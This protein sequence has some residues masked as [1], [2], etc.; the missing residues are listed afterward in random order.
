M[1]AWYYFSGWTSQQIPGQD[2]ARSWPGRGQG[3]SRL[4]RGFDQV[5][6]RSRP[7]RGQREYFRY[8]CDSLKIV[9][10]EYEDLLRN[11]SKTTKMPFLDILIIYT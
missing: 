4:L 7:G 2:A 5:V 6:A 10:G 1:D 8:L 11:I 3:A 9:L